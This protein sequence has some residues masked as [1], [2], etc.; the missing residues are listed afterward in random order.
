VGDGVLYVG[1]S[2]ARTFSRTTGER[3]T[4]RDPGACTLNVLAADTLDLLETIDM[5]VVGSEIYDIIPIDNVERWPSL[6]PIAWRDR[7]LLHAREGMQGHRDRKID[8][9][10]SELDNRTAIITD[11]DE[12]VTWLQGEIATRDGEIAAKDQRIAWLEAE[13]KEREKIIFERNLDISWLRDELGRP[14]RPANDTPQSCVDS[15]S[16][17]R[18]S[19]TCPLS[20]TRPTTART[21]NARP[22]S[23]RRARA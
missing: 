5:T 17:R 21:L 16:A 23:R 13:L 3:S 1:T 20:S 9:L 10:I 6:D 7:A 4:R 12:A 18:T 14:R 2:F 11:R 8:W 19:R 15:D 22:R